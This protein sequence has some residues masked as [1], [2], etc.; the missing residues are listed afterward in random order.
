MQEREDDE[1]INTIDISTPTPVG[2]LTRARAH[3]LNL[4][5]S[6]ILNSCRSYLDNGDTC[7]FMLLRNNG[8]DQQGKVQ[9]Y[10]ECEA[11]PTQG[12]IAYGKSDNLTKMI[13]DQVQASTTSS[14]KLPRRF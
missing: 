13:G 9:L 10:S 1:D 2:P 12:L 8:Q 7:N 6:S 3:Q 11:T 4:Q 5:V 14:I